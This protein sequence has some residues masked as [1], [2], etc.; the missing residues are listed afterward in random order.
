[1]APSR[2]IDR[3]P[4]KGFFNT[5]FDSSVNAPPPLPEAQ[6]AASIAGIVGGHLVAWD[7]LAQSA[8]WSVDYGRPGGGGTLS[9]AGM[10]VF[11]GDPQGR[12]TAHDAESGERLWSFDAQTAVMAGA[13]SYAVGGEQYVAVAVGSGG[14]FGHEGSALSH[15]WKL[16]NKSRVLGFKLGG[17]AQL[18]PLPPDERAMP[19]PAPVTASAETVA[20]G[21][22]MYQRYCSYCHGDGLRTGGLNPDLRWSSADIHAKWQDIVIGGML[23]PLGMVSFREFLTA[24]DAEAIRQYVLGEASRRYAELQAAPQPGS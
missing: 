9:T 20:H 21:R 22:T 13:V 4:G 17:T 19:E 5:G 1:V 8:R 23:Q 11:A 6:V 16:R 7:P 15:A 10:L 14:G 3:E 2:D 18:P 12:F 24:E